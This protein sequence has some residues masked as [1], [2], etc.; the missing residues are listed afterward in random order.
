M[1]ILRQYFNLL[2]KE[3]YDN[4]GGGNVLDIILVLSSLLTITLISSL[5]LVLLTSGESVGH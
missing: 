2:A 5:G 4:G 3:R 1:G